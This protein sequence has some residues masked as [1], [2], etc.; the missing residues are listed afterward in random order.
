LLQ[1]GTILLS[2]DVEKLFAV[3]E[4]P[5]RLDRAKTIA[6]VA[7]RLTSIEQAR[8][9]PVSYAEAEQAFSQGFATHFGFSP[10]QAE[11]TPEEARLALELQTAKYDNLAW[12]LQ[13]QRPTPAFG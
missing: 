8:R 4:L 3:L 2:V 10:A 6:Q 5:A 11:L 1:Q 13:R 9:R 12:N 7:G